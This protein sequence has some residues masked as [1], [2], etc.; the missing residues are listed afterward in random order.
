[1]HQPWLPAPVAVVLTCLLAV[2]GVSASAVSA[3]PTAAA[4]VAGPASAPAGPAAAVTLITGDTATLSR[5]ATGE[6][7]VSM[8]PTGDHPTSFTTLRRGADLYV[9][10]ASVENLVPDTLDLELFN[11]TGLIAQGY[12]DADTDTLPVIVRGGASPRAAGSDAVPLS[13][14]GATAVRL[15]KKNGFATTLDR[16]AGGTKVWL[17]RRVRAAELDGN[18][19][20]I[21]APQAWDAGLSGAGVD[22]AV[23]DT[24][25]DVDHPDLRGKVV[26]QANF[27]DDPTAEDGHGHGTH[28]ASIIGG[29][30]AA[31]GGA[32]KGVAYGA[33]LLS[34]KV[35]GADGRGQLS[36][37]IEG[38]E[39]AAAQGADVVNISLGGDAG[40]GDDPTA[41]ALDALSRDTGTLFV[42]AAGN[43][44]PGFATIGTPGIAADALTVGA[45]DPTG[46]PPYFSSQGPTRGTYRAKPD[47]TAPG[48][49]ITGALLGT[50]GYTTL[51]GTSQATP[52]VTGAAAL[53]RQAHPDWDW[54]HL[55]NA[56]MTTA[57]A[58]IAAPAP[59]A[60]GAGLL[61]IPGAL[62]DTLHLDRGNVD[63]GYLKYGAKATT[64]DI[65][66]KLTNDATTP[67]PVSFTD[68]ETDPA[69]ARAPAG[70]VTVTPATLTVPAGGTASVTVRL[71]P[72]GNGV[73]TGAVTLARQGKQPTRLPLGFYH[74]APRQDLTVTVLNRRGEP[75][76]YGTVWL[77]N[78]AE[79]NPETGGGFTILQLDENGRGTARM[80]PG[81]ISA[82]AR[83][84][85][86][87]SGRTPESVSFAGTPELTLDRDLAYTIDAR[88]AK[89]LKPVAV[90]GVR[91][92]VSTMSVH[93]GRQDAERDGGISDGIYAT[94]EEL[95]RGTV[96]VQPTPKVRSGLATFETHWEL[97]RGDDRYAV[98]L[99]SPNVPDPPAFTVRPSSFAR[100]DADYRSLG[101]R[102]DSYQTY[103]EPY[104]DLVYVTGRWVHPLAAPTRRTEWVTASKDVRWRQCVAGPQEGV[105]VLCQPTTTYRPG[106]RRPAVWFRAPVPAVTM[107]SHNRDRMELPVDL[108]DG[109]HEG[110]L[111]DV[112]A[113]GTRTFRLYRNGVEQPRFNDSWYFDTA[114]EPAMFRLEY[115][116][117][118]DT[119]RLP[120]GT[121]TSTAWT[122]PSAAPTDPEAWDTK[123]RLLSVDYQP[124][125]DGQGR[126][127]AWRI[128]DMGIRVT[129]WSAGETRLEPGAMRFWA[130]TDRG[131]RWHQGMVI[132][133]R[134]GSYRVIVP[135][136]VTKPGQKVS[137][138]VEASAAEG[139]TIKQTVVDAYPVR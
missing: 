13:S 85:T 57:D 95:A 50:D 137:V 22:V 12:G 119:K 98:V 135:G 34:G 123:P 128:L 60:E 117:E 48:V 118:P 78:M 16:A 53:L 33:R 54:Q 25:I 90:E 105:A 133:N 75:D 102:P 124:G 77:G 121:S 35:L 3:A 5:D 10:P 67:Q 17:D 76:A 8:T 49:D 46:L 96:F 89:Q 111:Y 139:R 82:I 28:V 1:M 21:G 136:V 37:L 115:T 84:V 129:S 14:I 94:G 112:D 127:P 70:M 80:T 24:G 132:P 65:T 92:T 109:D 30:G 20:Q 15:P 62:T 110:S 56:L 79:M 26:Q 72:G 101:G 73:Y 130:S 40:D 55:K 88:R 31:A 39:W 71:T 91:T 19:T 63:F 86:P 29:S 114:P 125:A 27:T 52:H 97:A 104:T 47:I 69:G 107:A 120:I 51:S 61:D 44:G 6:P 38:M 66:L 122:F 126:L 81:P 4:S 32:R 45:A 74:E 18:L 99:G 116:S 23:L 68:E 113:A 103:Q 59:Y 131:V 64:H 134:D 2:A 43:A 138:R 11:V 87:A 108:T 41:Q 7:R 58:R 9:V 93:Y 36:W 100:L 106:E 42:V 83:V